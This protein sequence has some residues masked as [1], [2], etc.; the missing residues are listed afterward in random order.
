MTK[1]LAPASQPFP[2]L[3]NATT[4][5]VN[6]RIRRDIRDLIDQA[7]QMQGKSRSEFMIEA[8]RR[9]AEDALL[10]QTLVRVDQQTYKEFVSLLDRPPMGSGFD[11]LMKVDRPWV[12]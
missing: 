12:E 9:E 3:V 5:V 10:D 1:E 2:P 4:Q 8:A 6:M 7:A 11:L